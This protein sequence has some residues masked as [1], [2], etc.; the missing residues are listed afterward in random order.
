V[1]N[2]WKWNFCRYELLLML[3][4]M[5]LWLKCGVYPTDAEYGYWTRHQWR[6]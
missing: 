4:M 5:L 2:Y 6:A 1:L 3:S